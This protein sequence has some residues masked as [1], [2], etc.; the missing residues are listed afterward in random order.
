MKKKE[1]LAPVGSM[2]C[3]KQ[4]IHN[5]A[6][7]VYLGCKNFGARKFATN[8]TNDE[9]IEA[10]KL[11]H[12]YGVKIYATMNTLIKDDE[13]SEFLNQIEFL[14]KNGIDAVIVQDF[15]MICLLREK[16]PNLEIHAST[17]ANTSAK[18]TAEL[19]YKLGV[20]R[21]VFSREMS[22]EEI[23]S[24]EV[25]IEK[26]VFVHGALCI[27]Y[28]GCCLMS[29]MIGTR[30]GNRGECAGSCRLPYSLE[31]NDKTINENKYL[32]STK[33]LNSA[34]YFKQILD[35]DIISFKIEGRMKSPEYVGFITNYYRNLI[36]NNGNIDIE[37]YNNQ[38][39]TIFNREFTKGH[40]LNCTAE[41]LMNT[42]T[43]NHIGLEIG[44]VVETTKD[45]IKIKLTHPLN[46][47][48]G[49][50]F[51]K[52]GT[53]FIVNYIYDEKGKMINSATDVCYID[54]KVGLTKNDVVA[55]TQDY[56]LMNKLKDYHLKKVPVTITA[57]CIL[58]TPL[59]IKISDKEN[60]VEVTGSKV[61]ASINAPITKDRLKQQMTKLGETPFTCE[62]IS[63]ECDDNIFI[64]IKE[65]NELRREAITKLIELRENKKKDFII[66]DV[67]F[68]N[69]KQA[70]IFGISASVYREDQ[71]EACLDLNLDRIYVADEKLYEKY[72]H[73]TNIYYKLP[74]CSR[75]IT[76]S[77]KEKNI[78]SDYFNFSNKDIIGDYGLNVYNAYTIYYLNRLGL[79]LVNASVELNEYEL[80]NLIRNYTEQFKC[81]PSIEILVYGRV[82]NMIIKDNILGIKENDYNYNLIDIRK[83]K[84][85]VYFD[86][87]NTHILNYQNNELNPSKIIDKVAIRFDFYNESATQIKQIV[88]SQSP[89][90]YCC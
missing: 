19:F 1:L 25:P 14:H 63:I 66:K 43:P 52:S 20:K 10:I 72:K 41:E 69:T 88:K 85:P 13:V 56:K 3:L 74:R 58:G 18:E 28:S 86:N 67:S 61:A 39:K 84:F 40:L 7:A 29:S 32:L 21:V 11:C 38:L 73:L 30:S 5:G 89:I 59:E 35:S 79:T 47:Q 6:D 76:S 42:N 50:R 54:N 81:Y 16:Y 68:K 9:I 83:R 60:L 75:N 77:L 33:E 45:K 48:D 78:S 57:K 44:R 55:K 82:E 64:S 53:G 37:E 36:D 2:E 4:A 17:Q 22:I 65:I 27:S 71:L 23:K 24:I 31:H 49:I 15:G 26:E 51:L 34:P 87:T 90:N 80:N 8:F 62:N 70:N 46:Q 12:L